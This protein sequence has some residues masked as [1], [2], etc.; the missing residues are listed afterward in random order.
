[1]LFNDNLQYNIGYGGV[2]EDI[3]ST[4]NMTKIEKAAQRAKIYDFVMN[5]HEK[6]QT[7][8][9]ERGLRLSG[10]EK[11]RVAIARA[12]L[13]KRA[14]IYCFDEA[15]SALDT[16]TEREIQEAINEVSAGTTTLMIA[17]R[18]STVKDCDKII[19][20]K[21]GVVTE[22]GKHEELLK[23]EDGIYRKLWEE[24][25]KKMLEKDDDQQP[26]ED[27]DFVPLYCDPHAAQKNP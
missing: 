14:L 12:L 25:T 24:Q 17:H 20:L 1:M 22:E 11:Q 4:E 15:T 23:L 26:K 19:V 16:T 5:Q 3:H 18:L 10:G 13:K 7:A 21:K 27:D 6:W 8:V 2:G 9:G